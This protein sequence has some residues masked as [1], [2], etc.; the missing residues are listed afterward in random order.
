MRLDDNIG[1][2]KC[3]EE[4]DKVLAVFCLDPRQ[5]NPRKN[6]YFSHHAFGFMN[7]SLQYLNKELNNKL[8]LL[9]GEP[10]KVLPGII[11]KYNILNIYINTDY[12]P[13][14]KKRTE[15]LK[16]VLPV[17]EYQDYLLFNPGTITTGSNRAYRVYTP[18]LNKTKH[19]KVNRPIM[20]S[21]KLKNKFIKNIKVNN[22]GWK[23]LEKYS[24]YSELYVPGNR[25]EGLR[26]LEK[27]AETQKNY[28]KCRNYLKY[29]TSNLSAYIKFGCIS[30]REVW[31]AFNNI[32]GK[33]GRG[34]KDQLIWREFYYHYYNDFP[35]YL[36]WEKKSKEV[37]IK[38][39]YPEIVQQCYNDLDKT[40]FLHNR[41]RMILANYLL[42]NKKKYWKD[43]DKMYAKRLVDYDPLV[44]IGNWLWIKKQPK[45][46]WLKPE[47]QNKKWNKICKI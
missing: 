20:L 7:Q 42:H 16:K 24:K 4:S 30:I 19:K 21:N 31:E 40:G 10:H 13:F 3:L 11:K 26:R 38:S 17:K 2:I 23:Y 44:N 28:A 18:F 33:S 27:I 8:L 36:E 45:F 35:E 1:L 37:G 43:C 41:G 32:R 22:K 46:K 29:R 9:E 34:L 15:E 25:E 47:V 12:T 39:S 5:A 6:S 14:A